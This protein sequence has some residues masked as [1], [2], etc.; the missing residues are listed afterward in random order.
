MAFST[1]TINL[2]DLSRGTDPSA[3]YDRLGTALSANAAAALAGLGGVH[4]LA[5]GVMALVDVY[6][7]DPNTG[8]L[9]SAQAVL[10]VHASATSSL[11]TVQVQIIPAV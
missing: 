5:R 4:A 3:L 8:P 7:K 2:V 1:A 11:L 10:S 9:L 6:R